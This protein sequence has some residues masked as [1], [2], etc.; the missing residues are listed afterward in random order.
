MKGVIL[1]GSCHCHGCQVMFSGAAGSSQRSGGGSE[2]QKEEK[3]APAQQQSPKHRDQP[4]FE[5][6]GM[7]GS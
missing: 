3:K 1:A 6:G 4:S 7:W 2:Q 5:V